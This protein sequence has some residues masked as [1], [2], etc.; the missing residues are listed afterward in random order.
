MEV[1]FCGVFSIASSS[2][3]AFKYFLKI[4]LILK[5][6]KL[7]FLSVLKVFKVIVFWE[8]QILEK[9]CSYTFKNIIC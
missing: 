7:I 2:S 3:A 5:Y 6:I 8:V 9:H 1:F 4:F